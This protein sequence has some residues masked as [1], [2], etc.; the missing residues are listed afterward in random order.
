MIAEALKRRTPSEVKTLLKRV[1]RVLPYRIRNGKIFNKTYELLK[2]S[3]WWSEAQ[4]HDYQNEQLQLLIKHAYE[5][6]P[7]YHKVFRDCKLTPADIRTAEDLP[8]LPLLTKDIIR[9]NIRDLV[10]KNIPTSELEE[11]KTSG[12]TVSPLSFFWHKNL[13]DQRE[14]AFLWTSWNIGGYR[15]NHPRVDFSLERT[16]QGSIQYDPLERVL[17]LSAVALG[18]KQ[19]D[20]YIKIMREYRP[21][22]LKSIP[23]NLLPLARHMVDQRQPRFDSLQ[24]IL[25]GS[26][27][28]YPW[29]RSLIEDVFGVRLFSWYGQTERVILGTECEQSCFYHL[30]PEYGIT[31]IVDAGGIPVSSA[32]T[33]GRMVGTGFNN[34]AMP[35]LRYQLGD[36]GAV[37]AKGC[38][39][40]RSYPILSIL[41]GREQEYIINA[42]GEAIPIVSITYS[43]ILE[44]AKQF[45]FY[46]E[47]EGLVTL[48]VVPFSII[49]QLDIESMRQKLEKELSDV[50]VRIALVDKIPRGGRGKSKYIIQKLPIE[51]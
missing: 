31:E 32:G 38:P 29:Q 10:A 35:L 25:C 3:Q 45:Q 7:F 36:I 24:L 23:S 19:L 20:R 39:C 21:K 37:S 6:V 30:F 43:S 1:A 12:S 22:V 51:I 40:G 27:M 50:D 14:K 11:T 33:K 16:E 48:N 2:R 47:R 15:F 13:T 17:L 5:H 9:I 46:Q 44:K 42:K 8:K 18:R 28:I 26:E 49:T 41:E 4:L 34:Y